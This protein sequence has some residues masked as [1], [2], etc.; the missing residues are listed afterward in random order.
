MIVNLAY[1]AKPTRGG[2]PTYTAH[3]AHGLRAAGHDV[4]LWRLGRRTETTGRP[5]GRGLWYRN[6]SAEFLAELARAEILHI[7]A[8]EPS[9]APAVEGILR[10]GGSITIHDPTEL[11]QGMPGALAYAR[12]PIV[13]IRSRM[14]SHVHQLGREA[15]YVPHPY[16]RMAAQP[17]VTASRHAVAF[18][19]LDWDKGTHHIVEANLTLP[20]EQAVQLYGAENRMYAHHKLDPIDPDWRRNYHGPWPVTDLWGGARIARGA[21]AAVDLSAIKGD[22]GGTQYTFLEALDTGVPLVLNQAWLTGDAACDELLDAAVFIDPA[23]LAVVLGGGLPHR[24]TAALLARHDA[25][26]RSLEAVGLA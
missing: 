10:A 19:R 18:S 6:A 17:P 3:L 13:V 21:R 23:K 7:A 22:G 14:Q 26:A 12:K 25:T 16:A 20:P 4:S 8:A 2:W 5:F 9:V 11:K 1:L 24:E 15:R